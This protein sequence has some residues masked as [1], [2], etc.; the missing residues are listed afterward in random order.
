MLYERFSK[1]SRKALYTARLTALR[2]GTTSINSEY[3]LLGLLASANARANRV[4][5]LRELLH[6]L[7]VRQMRLGRLEVADPNTP[8][9]LTADASRVLAYAEKEANL[10]RQWWVDTDHIYL[11]L[12]REDDPCVHEALARVGFSLEEARNFVTVNEWTRPSYGRSPVLWW[13]Y[14][15]PYRNFAIVSVFLILLIF[16][17]PFFAGK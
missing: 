10:M 14:P 12:L 17:V 9:Y 3:I 1:G 2:A 8:M 16:V 5:H 4:F 15:H 7:G 6:G 11:A 13:H